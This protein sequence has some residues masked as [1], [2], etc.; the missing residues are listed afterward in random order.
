MSSYQN[1]LSVGDLV[2]ADCHIFSFFKQKLNLLILE[3][4]F[5][6]E[7]NTR[8]GLRQFYEYKVLCLENNDFF[9]TKTQNLRVYKITKS[10]KGIK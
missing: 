6:F 4:E 9:K 8:Y 7:K 3:R 10:R 1:G 5:L 2:Y